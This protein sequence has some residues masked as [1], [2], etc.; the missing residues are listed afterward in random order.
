MNKPSFTVVTCVLIVFVILAFGR[1]SFIGLIPPATTNELANSPQKFLSFAGHEEI[2]WHLI[3][4]NPFAEARRLKKPILLVVGV[5]S[6][7]LGHEFDSKAFQDID[8]VRFLA[9]YFY[10][11]RIDGYEHPEWLNAIMPVSRLKVG[12]NPGFQVWTLDADGHILSYIGQANGGNQLDTPGIYKALIDARDQYAIT[13]SRASKN[14]PIPDLQA[15]DLQYLSTHPG[16]ALPSLTAYAEVLGT[17]CDRQNGGFPHGDL[18]ELYPNAWRFLSLT[19]NTDLWHRSLGPLLFSKMVDIQEGGFF[20]AGLTRDV[21]RVEFDKSSR[22][23][24]EMMAALAIQA[25][26]EQDSFLKDLAESTFEWLNLSATRNGLLAACQEDDENPQGRSPRLSFPGWRLRDLLGH[27]D[28]AWASAQL[29]L[30]PVS[31]PQMVPYLRTRTVLLNENFRLKRVL[32]LLHGGISDPPSYNDAGY[33]DTNGDS[34]ARMLEVSR[35]W[36]DE[37]RLSSLQPLISKMGAFSDTT[38]LTHWAKDEDK[39]MGY[40]GD[41]LAFSD[42]RLQQYL[43]MGQPNAL[44]SG[45]DYLN[46]ARKLFQGPRPGQMNLSKDVSQMGGFSSLCVPEIADNLAESCT[47]QAI[48]LELAYGRLLA[49]T[50]QGEELIRS[51]RQTTAV[52]ADIASRGGPGTAGY[53]CAA[54]EVLDDLYAVAVGPNAAPLADALYRKVPTRFVAPALGR[55]RK[56]LQAKSPGIYLVGKTVSGPFTVEEAAHRLPLAL[57]SRELP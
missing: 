15:P 13:K 47:A 49:D 33:M 7:K 32:D 23:N 36:G 44:Q 54:A 10:C 21:N 29:G 30:D 12:F 5:S 34:L 42:A 14:V 20:R 39:I 52:F 25:Q 43:A 40:L 26:I 48:R 45:L 55:F 38:D 56:D 57:A 19:C 37:S 8:T 11:I 31:N 18:Q 24:A 28:S 16:V 9:Q 4:N 1:H 50:T 27:E 2:E 41:Y 35:L 51:A 3:E 46:L 6:N 22:Q 17:K 53:F